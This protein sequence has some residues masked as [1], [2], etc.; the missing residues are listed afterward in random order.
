MIKITFCT[1][2]FWITITQLCSITYLKKNRLMGHY[3]S[4]SSQLYLKNDSNN[5]EQ[6]SYPTILRYPKNIG[7]NHMLEKFVS[8]SFFVP[9]VKGQANQILKKCLKCLTQ[10]YIFLIPM[11]RKLLWQ[12]IQSRIFNQSFIFVSLLVCLK[13][14]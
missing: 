11:T 5:C 8:G 4:G 2:M 14:V 13:N 7:L 10:F 6:V 12:I 9:M 1:G 3:E